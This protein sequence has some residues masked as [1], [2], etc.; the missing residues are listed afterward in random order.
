VHLLSPDLNIR[1]GVY[2][3]H[4]IKGEYKLDYYLHGI[5]VN[6]QLGRLIM[7]ATYNVNSLSSF[8]C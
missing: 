1:R 5:M 2:K 4:E 6:G 7:L 8:S 3:E